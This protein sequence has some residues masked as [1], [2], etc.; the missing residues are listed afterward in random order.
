MVNGTDL[1]YAIPQELIGTFSGLIFVLKTL[2][3][4]IIFY[5]IFSLINL[6]LNKKKNRTMNLILKNLEE[7]RIILGNKLKDN[8][9]I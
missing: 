5:I 4:V 2:G 8:K 3:W 6:F 7:I 1:I 9:N